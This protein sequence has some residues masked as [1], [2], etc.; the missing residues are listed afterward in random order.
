MVH[1]LAKGPGS[2]AWHEKNNIFSMVRQSVVRSTH[3]SNQGIKIAQDKG[4]A[5]VDVQE[6]MQGLKEF[7]SGDA[8]V[9]LVY[10]FGSRASDRAG[11]GSDYDLGILLHRG[12][13]SPA[14]RARLTHDLVVI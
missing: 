12:E 8:A 6:L 9:L 2:T 3:F 5:P 10:L 13:D 14:R 7:G 4:L 11:P 1:G